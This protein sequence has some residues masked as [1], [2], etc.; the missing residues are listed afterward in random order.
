[1]IDRHCLGARSRAV[2]LGAALAVAACQQAA[3][4]PPAPAPKVATPPPAAVAPPPAS[5]AKAPPVALPSLDFPAGPLYYCDAA[6]VR[7]PIVYESRVDGICRRHPEM[8]PCQYEREQCRAKGGRV[9]TARGEEVT[10]AVEA[11]YDKVV[12]RVRFQADSG[13]K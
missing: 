12:R 8:G 9:F 13:R 1:M 5:V 10:L 7:Q 4:P 3:P 11:E 6:G 2:A